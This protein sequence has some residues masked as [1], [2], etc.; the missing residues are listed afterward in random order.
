MFDSSSGEIPATDAPFDVPAGGPRHR[1]LTRCRRWR[2]HKKAWQRLRDDSFPG[3][4]LAEL[5]AAGK[6]RP[7][8]LAE[9]KYALREILSHHAVELLEWVLAAQ[10]GFRKRGGIIL[11]HGDAA[12]LLGCSQRTAG[13]AMRA[14]VALGLVEQRPHFR[15]LSVEERGEELAAKAAGRHPT[16]LRPGFRGPERALKHVE[17]TP[18]YRTTALC[19]AVVARRL[20]RRFSGCAQV[21]KKYQPAPPKEFSLREND[22]GVPARWPERVFVDAVLAKRRPIDVTTTTAEVWMRGPGGK[23]LRAPVDSARLAQRLRTKGDPLADLGD[24]AD[25]VLSALRAFERAAAPRPTTDNRP[26]QRQD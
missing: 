10:R 3:K 12:K 18:A 1:A 8:D 17:M 20:D 15:K 5:A 13:D 21:G 14:L 22:K 24:V 26:N 11:K 9:V 4:R 23:R 2:R 16:T 6:A 19:D 25:A 7:Y